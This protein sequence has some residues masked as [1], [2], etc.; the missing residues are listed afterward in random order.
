MDDVVNLAQQLLKRPLLP[1]EIV[2]LEKLYQHVKICISL[3]NDDLILECCKTFVLNVV[4]FEEQRHNTNN[5]NTN[6]NNNNNNNNTNNTTTTTTNNNNNNNNK[7]SSNYQLPV[8][9]KFVS[10]EW[11]KQQTTPCRSIL[12]PPSPPSPT[13]TEEQHRSDNPANTF[14]SQMTTTSLVAHDDKSLQERYSEIPRCDCVLMG[15]LHVEEMSGVECLVLVDNTG[16]LPVEILSTFFASSSTECALPLLLE[17]PVLLPAWHYIPSLVDNNACSFHYLELTQCPL[18]L[19]TRNIS[20]QVCAVF[21]IFFLYTP[22][23]TLSLFLSV[24]SFLQLCI[25]FAYA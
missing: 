24:R 16:T 21:S 1:P 15:T 11:L 22:T 12:R 9:W 2:W 18:P 7:V 6:N 10:I 8:Q 19:L 4:C 5:N 13:P 14:S 23:H 20:P 3:E 25:L 17:R